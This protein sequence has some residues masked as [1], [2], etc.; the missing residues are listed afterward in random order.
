MARVGREVVTKE[1]FVEAIN[2]LHK[3]NRVGKGLSEEES[4]AKQ[5]YR[6]FLNELIDVRLFRIEAENM[7]FDKEP[8]FVGT[9]EN[10]VLNVNLN[11]LRQ[12]EIVKKVVVTDKEIEDYYR[13]S[14]ARRKE[15]LEKAG[16]DGAVKETPKPPEGH[17]HFAQEDKKEADEQTSKE[18]DAAVKEADKIPQKERDRI[19]DKIYAGKL[20]ERQAEFFAVLRGKAAIKIDDAALKDLS[21]DKPDTLDKAVAEVDGKAILGREIAAFKDGKKGADTEEARRQTLDRLILHRLLDQEA[22]KRNYASTPENMARIKSYS[23]RLLVNEFRRKI[24]AASIK[25][26]EN[27]TAEYYEKNKESFREPDTVDVGVIV[28]EKREKAEEILDEI[29]KGAD[30]SYLASLKSIDQSGKSGGQVGKINLYSF[31]EDIRK[32]L[33]AAKSGEIIGPVEVSGTW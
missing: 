20:N 13:D 9:M 2:N 22:V 5:D 24:I 15:E 21:E 31:P 11:A 17:P 7:G 1:D 19:R 23:D 4:F 3:S 6:K 14:A 32:T 12:E 25:I 29:K 28:V 26:D 8:G 27:E 10:Y 18:G 16:K 33:L 30:F